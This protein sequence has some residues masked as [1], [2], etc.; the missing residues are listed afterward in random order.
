[1]KHMP[2]LAEVMTAFP[3]HV[4]EN[5]SLVSAAALMSEHGCHHLPV[6]DGH[7]VV[8]VLGAE[9]IKLAQTPGHD[10]DESQGLTAGDLCQR[11]F[12]Q[13]DLH[14]RLDVV[15]QGMAQDSRSAV[16]V[17][18]QDRLAGIL[19]SQDACRYFALWL[20]KEYLGED[21]PGVA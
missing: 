16:V 4:A 1:M 3:V 8:G 10:L 19:T 7:A 21:D 15:L 6:L 5:V 11:R 9:D 12:A 17:L 18:R 13:V 2:T 14:T 20:R